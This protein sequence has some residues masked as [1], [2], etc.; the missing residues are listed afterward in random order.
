MSGEEESIVYFKTKKISESTEVETNF[1]QNLRNM[2]RMKHLVSGHMWW[3]KGNLETE[4]QQGNQ[5]L[6]FHF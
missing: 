2:R 5:L 6:W 3:L 4:L 1:M